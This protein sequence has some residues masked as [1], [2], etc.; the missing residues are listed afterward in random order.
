MFVLIQ[1]RFAGVLIHID[2]PVLDSRQFFEFLSGQSAMNL[3]TFRAHV[4]P[5]VCMADFLI[6]ACP[7]GP[8]QTIHVQPP[9]FSDGK[10]IHVRRHPVCIS[11]CCGA[12]PCF[13]SPDLKP[14]WSY[15]SAVGQAE[16]KKQAWGSEGEWSRLQGRLSSGSK[17]HLWPL[18]QLLLVLTPKTWTKG[19]N[20]YTIHLMRMETPSN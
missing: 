10:D 17:Q 9:K 1:F 2:W 8:M 20:S 4:A 18:V 6:S 19:Q 16:S 3:T 11:F 13:Q 15:L 12:L 7:L 5:V 14:I